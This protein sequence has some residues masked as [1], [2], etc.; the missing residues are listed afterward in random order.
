M[1]LAKALSPR[2]PRRA[3][4]APA[5]KNAVTSLTLPE[6]VTTMGMTTSSGQNVT[7]ENSKN[8]ATA[9]RCGNIISDD[10]AKLPLQIFVSKEPGHLERMK[11]DGFSRNI[12][13]RV[14]KQPNRWWT[15]FW[16][17]KIVIQWLLYWGNCYI[18]QPPTGQRELFVLSADVTYAVFAPNGDL[19]YATT[20]P[21]ESK[22]TFL[23][24]VEVLHLLINP[25]ATG[26]KGRGVI[27]FARETLGRQ[28]AAYGSQGALFK[29]GLSAAGILWLSGESSPEM[30]AK[31]RDMYE[32]VMSGNENTGRIAVL[33]KKIAKFEPVTLQ[34]KDVQFLQM[35][36]ENDIAIMNFFGM[37]S[38]KLNIGKQSYQSNEQNNLDYLS[39]T[40]DPFLVQWEE[41]A[42]VKWLSVEEQVYAYF[43]FERSALFRTDAKSRGEYLNGAINNSRLT[44]NEAR[45]VEDRPKSDNPAADLLYIN[46]SA[47]PIG[48]NRSNQ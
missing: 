47:Q 10:V 3:T 34:P 36:Q 7:A 4:A 5:V 42:G 1:I 14:E 23:P 45:Q 16:F 15:P 43:R 17:K 30:R 44:P 37:P 41:S 12:A 2:T 9:Y 19:W 24:A 6:L 13:W 11:P 18:W 8:I 28:L 31:V 27:Q 22:Q 35:M 48:V 39:T 21:G 32:E 29:N 38:Y 20:F 40:L 46:S 25:D 33:D 26:F